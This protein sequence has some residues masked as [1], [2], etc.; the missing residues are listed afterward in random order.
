MSEI[1][2]AKLYEAFGLTPTEQGEQVQ[3]TAEPAAETDSQT[4]NGEQ[5]QEL[6][7]PAQPETDTD[8]GDEAESDADSDDPDE[9][10]PQTDKDTGKDKQ[11]LTPE[12][13]RANA[14][15]RRAL[16]QQEATQ[17]AVDAAVQAEQLKSKQMLEQVLALAGIKNAS[18]GETITTIEDFQ[19]W[20]KEMADARLEKDLKA[21]KLT[22]EVLE[23]LISAHPA[24]QQAQ[25]IQQQMQTQQNQ[26]KAEAERAR[27]EGQFAKI[28]ELNPNIKGLADILA[29]DTASAFRENV[30]KG[31]DFYD[32]YRLANMDSMAQQKA[33]RAV[34]ASQ[35]NA[36]GK[37]HLKAT[38]NA[39][40]SG[41][42]S[43]PQ[44]EMKLYRMMNPNMTDAQIQAHYNKYL[45]RGG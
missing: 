35:N 20:S 9:E 25:Q 45:K 6:A 13:R 36:R 27:I 2:E 3:E 23:Q 34:Q 32:A 24:V 28:A 16:E 18:T 7:E 31:M 43:V 29:M 41:A 15:R 39:R 19:Q 37:E 8:T 44:A 12:Q 5:E 21:G 11:P 40:G 30:A 1:T 38:G 42:A 26:Q 4:G 17:K 33:Q 14:A 10:D 22:R